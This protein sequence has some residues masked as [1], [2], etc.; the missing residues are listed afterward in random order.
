MPE[1]SGVLERFISKSPTDGDVG[2]ELLA[3]MKSELKAGNAEQLAGVFPSLLLPD[4]DYTVYT[5]SS[6]KPEAH[7][8][9]PGTSS[10]SPFS[11]A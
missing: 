9:V 2:N 3:W 1:N 6:R 7:T 5:A 10:R 4:L 11:A 8:P